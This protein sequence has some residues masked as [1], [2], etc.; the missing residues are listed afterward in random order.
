MSYVLRHL[1]L[2]VS[3]V[4]RVLEKH[5]KLKRDRSKMQRSGGRSDSDV[6]AATNGADST[7]MSMH[8]DEQDEVKI[9]T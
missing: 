1:C 3:G 5:S 6:S 4:L 8:A 2:C 7:T 9:E